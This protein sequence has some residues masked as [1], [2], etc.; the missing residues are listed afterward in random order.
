MLVNAEGVECLAVGVAPH[1]VLVD[2]LAHVLGHFFVNVPVP[3]LGLI[4]EVTFGRDGA[5]RSWLLFA[6]VTGFLVFAEKDGACQA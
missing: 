5:R 2:A 6:A 3:V 1:A 4:L